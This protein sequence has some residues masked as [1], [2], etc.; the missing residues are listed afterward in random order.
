MFLAVAAGE[1]V[2]LLLV[3]VLPHLQTPCTYDYV[4]STFIRTLFLLAG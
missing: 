4:C 3:G 1:G 2:F